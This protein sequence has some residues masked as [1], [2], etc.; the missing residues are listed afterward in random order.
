MY[1]L[2]TCA[3]PCNTQALHPLTPSPCPLPLPH[4]T[5]VLHSLSQ[6]LLHPVTRPHHPITLSIILLYPLPYPLVP[7]HLLLHPITLPHPF[8]S[9]HTERGTFPEPGSTGLQ[10]VHSSHSR[11]GPASNC[12]GTASTPCLVAQRQTV[13]TEPPSKGAAGCAGAW[14]RGS[15]NTQGCSD[16]RGFWEVAGLTW[17]TAGRCPC[18]LHEKHRPGVRSPTS[19]R[20]LW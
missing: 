10:T 3:P 7:C 15:S 14:D 2:H 5:T 18:V 8:P 6:P 16:L 19:S 17:G 11:V 20:K 4:P 13:E 1:T 9:I 12:A